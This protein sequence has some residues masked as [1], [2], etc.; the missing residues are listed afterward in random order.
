[1]KTIS[2][3]PANEE[4]IPFLK[5]LLSNPAWV[6]DIT[7]HDDRQADEISAADEQMPFLCSADEL[8]ESL[9]RIEEEFS[10]GKT[11]GFTS[12]QMRKKHAL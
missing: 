7:I 9:Y 3:K 6:T 8:N 5:E 11:G 12:A 2:I 1:M 10:Q 4:I